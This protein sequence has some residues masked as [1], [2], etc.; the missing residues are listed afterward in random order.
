MGT[1]NNMATMLRA[2]ARQGRALHRFQT[3]RQQPSCFITTSKKNKDFAAPVE[4]MPKSD[5]LKKLEEHFAD[6][7]P[8]SD[9]NWT[10][11]GFDPTDP[12]LDNFA[13][14]TTMFFTITLCVC[15]GAFILAY[16]PDHKNLSWVTRESFLELE[17]REKEG[18]ALVSPDLVDPSTITIPSDE[19]L[20]DAEIIV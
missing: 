3:L 8:N 1:G 20:G 13:H 6:T 18:L 5:E 7:D 15:W 4:A 11:Y 14:H 12:D 19:E 2:L 10:S 9:K 17:R 16:Q